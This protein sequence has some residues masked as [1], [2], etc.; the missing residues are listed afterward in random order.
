[1]NSLYRVI[2]GDVISFRVDA[3][4]FALRTRA[5]V[6][7]R[8]FYTGFCLVYYVV[9]DDRYGVSIVGHARAEEFVS[10]CIF[11]FFVWKF[12]E[13]TMVNHGACVG[14]FLTVWGQAVCCPTVRDVSV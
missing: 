12:I 1:M 3:C 11:V 10:G 6:V 4:V 2:L 13:N 8:W 5:I 9:G 14:G 7:G